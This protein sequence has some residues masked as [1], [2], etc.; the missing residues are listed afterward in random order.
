MPRCAASSSTSA[1][2]RTAEDAP[3]APA[4]A[5]RTRCRRLLTPARSRRSSPRQG[6]AAVGAERR[7]RVPAR[8][9]DELEIAGYDGYTDADVEPF[10]RIP[11]HRRVPAARGGAHGRAAVPRAAPSGR[12]LPRPDDWRRLAGDGQFVAAAAR[13]PTGG[14]GSLALRM[15]RRPPGRGR[16]PRRARRAR[17]RVRAGA[18]A[19]RARGAERGAP[20]RGGRQRC[21]GHDHH[22][23][24]R[25]VRAVRHATCAT[26]ASTTRWRRSTASRPP[27]TSG[28]RCRRSSRASPPRATRSRCGGCWRPASRSSTSR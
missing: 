2:R 16:R 28:A 14:L 13:R 5:H 7:R 4:A 12:A 10:C 24:A 20:Q 9:D 27:T 25:G 15:P 22:H 11:L 19:R 3:G 8:R 23:R 18:A 1:S 21:A 26:C 17:A 6:R